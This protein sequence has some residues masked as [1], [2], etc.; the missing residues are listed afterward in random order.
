MKIFALGFIL[1]AVVCFVVTRVVDRPAPAQRVVVIEQAPVRSPSPAATPPPATPSCPEIK[2]V[3]ASA[4]PPAPASITNVVRHISIEDFTDE[5]AQQICAQSYQRQQQRERDK[6]NAEPIDAAWAP[7]MEMLIRQHVES[8]LTRKQY[9]QLDIQCRTT[10]C[11]LKIK[12]PNPADLEP[13]H[14]LVQDIAN[15]PWA[16]SLVNRGG[17]TSGGETWDVTQEWFRPRTEAEM[18]MWRRIRQN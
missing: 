1:G 13:V 10:F 4:P 12:G 9:S 5:E 2:S 7:S 11:E 18:R 3:E 14:Q 15:Q 17:G 16:G 8:N 6:K